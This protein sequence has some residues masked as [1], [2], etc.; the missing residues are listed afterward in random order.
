MTMIRTTTLKSL[1]LATLMVVKKQEQ[2]IHQS[3][4]VVNQ[5]QKL[6]YYSTVCGTM[7]YLTCF[8]SVLLNNFQ[9]Q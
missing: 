7:E 8:I 2:K 3:Q 4:A 1:L 6:A 5:D 9:L